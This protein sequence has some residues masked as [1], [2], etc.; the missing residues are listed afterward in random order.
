MTY[1]TSTS[2]SCQVRLAVPNCCCIAFTGEDG[3]IQNEWGS[4]ALQK[5]FKKMVEQKGP[6]SFD[7]VSV[8]MGFFWVMSS[9]EQTMIEGWHNNLLQN[10]TAWKRKSP[11]DF[12]KK[13]PASSSAN[14]TASAKKVKTAEDDL[15]ELFGGP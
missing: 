4:D 5:Y 1:C 15:S 12:P 2:L 8:L 3:K 7:E 13:E 10:L 11:G 9:T 14:D 6:K